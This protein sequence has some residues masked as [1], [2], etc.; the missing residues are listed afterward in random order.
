[1]KGEC[2]RNLHE[3]EFSRSE[4]HYANDFGSEATLPISPV[5]RPVG[6]ITR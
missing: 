3:I 4:A 5:G 2:A 6:G 1:M